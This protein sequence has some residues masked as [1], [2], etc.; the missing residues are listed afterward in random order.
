MSFP[1]M[2]FFLVE[3]GFKKLYVAL[4]LFIPNVILKKLRFQY[5]LSIACHKDP[6][7]II[8]ERRRKKIIDIKFPS[9]ST[10]IIR[11]YTLLMQKNNT[12]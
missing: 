3:V 5:F 6:K 4:K 10:I 8:K 7:F 1:R 11:I 9:D 2:V 12:T